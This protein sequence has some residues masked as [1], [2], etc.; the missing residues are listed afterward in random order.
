MLGL[1]AKQSSVWEV[2]SKGKTLEKTAKEL[3]TSKQNIHQTL[4]IA[5]GILSKAL[6]EIAD[7]DHLEVKKLDPAAGVLWGYHRL[8]DN[9]VVVT[10]LPKRGVRVWYWTKNIED[11]K[12]PR[13]L[14]DSKR[15]LLE[16]AE[17]RGIALSKDQRTSHPAKLA[18]LIF[19]E[20]VPELQ[21]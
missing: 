13:I 12:D 20:L 18:Q 15:Y 19:K 11:V 10:F 17:E 9:D 1:T 7:A 3:G 4:R 16:I 21:R 6:L 2:A 5:Q 14:E 8:L